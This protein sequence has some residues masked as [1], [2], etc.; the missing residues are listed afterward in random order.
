MYGILKLVN[1][2]HGDF[3]TLGGYVAFA[4][5]VSAGMPLAVAFLGAIAAVAALGLVLE[6][7]D[8]GA[9]AAPRARASC[10]CCCCRSGWRSSS[11]T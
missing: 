2:A 8:L 10:S 11:A 4:I 5:N 7:D 6:F 1:F 3:I 9:D